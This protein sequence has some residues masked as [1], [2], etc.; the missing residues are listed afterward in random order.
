MERQSHATCYNGGNPNGQFAQV[1]KPAHATVLRNAVAPQVG[2]PFRQ[3][4]L[5][6]TPKTGQPHHSAGSS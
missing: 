1:G 4:L 5:G 6:G 3:F 2:K